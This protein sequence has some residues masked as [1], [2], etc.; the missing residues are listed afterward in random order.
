MRLF[1]RY[2][3]NQEQ[4]RYAYQRNL[5]LQRGK[6]MVPGSISGVALD[7]DTSQWELCAFSF[8]APCKSKTRPHLN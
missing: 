8:C 1:F 7:E 5:R 4:R 3:V 6:E 2:G